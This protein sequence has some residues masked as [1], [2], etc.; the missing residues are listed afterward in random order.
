MANY[1]AIKARLV[2]HSTTAIV[3]VDDPDSAAIAQ[4]ISIEGR[5]PSRP[6]SVAGNMV[7]RG[8]TLDGTVLMRHRDM[9]ATAHRRPR[10]H[11]VAARRP[12]RAERR[13]RDPRPGRGCLQPQPAAGCAAASFPGL[14]HRMEQIAAR[15]GVIFVNDSKA[16]N[17]DAAERRRCSPSLAC[18]GSSAARPRRAAS[19]RVRPLFERVAK[20][21]LIG[22]AADLFAETLGPEGTVGALRHAR[23]RH[24]PRRGGRAHAE[25]ERTGSRPGR[26]A[27]AG[28]R[29]PGPVQRL[30][31]AG[32]IFPRCS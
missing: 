26:A 6:V 22:A 32:R 23:R 17:A 21:Y 15:D 2:A 24:A 12:Q 16:T 25:V 3:S 9:A 7:A 1:A 30:R 5:A 29:Q 28:L 14:A 13:R 27:L 31:A 4:A 11:R 8:I 20:A 19:S 10:R 18:T